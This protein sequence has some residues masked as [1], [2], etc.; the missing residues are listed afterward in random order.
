M[1]IKG[2][3][4]NVPCCEHAIDY[5]TAERRHHPK[6]EE[7]NGCHQ[8]G[9]EDR[10]MWSFNPKKPSLEHSQ[11]PIGADGQTNRLFTSMHQ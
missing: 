4:H 1:P 5:G 9:E 2:S 3:T 8:L 11:S 10:G 6:A 7:H